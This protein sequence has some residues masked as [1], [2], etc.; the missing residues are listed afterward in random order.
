MVIVTRGAGYIGSHCVR[1][2][3][4][5]VETAVGQSPPTRSAAVDSRAEGV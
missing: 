4:G 2:L 5:G 3:D 1:L